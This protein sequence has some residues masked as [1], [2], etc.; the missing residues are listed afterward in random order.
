MGVSVEGGRSRSVDAETNL[1]PFIDVMSCLV[2][3]LLLTAAWTSAAQLKVGTRAG[4]RSELL[5]ATPAP[6]VVVTRDALF[7]EDTRIDGRDYAAL[8]RALDDLEAR[9]RGDTLDV[10]ADPGVAF[11]DVVTTMDVAITHGFPDVRYGVK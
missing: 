8:A 5:P 9:G 7:V 4:E 6:A 1:I 10:R 3:F 11:Q 2:A